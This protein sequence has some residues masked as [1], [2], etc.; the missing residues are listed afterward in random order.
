VVK[1]LQLTNKEIDNIIDLALA[2]DVSHGDV[3]SETLIPLGLQGQASILARAEGVLAGIEVVR[4]VFLRVD[5]LLKFERRLEDGARVRLG[6]GVANISGRVVSILKGERVVLNFLSRLSGVATAT[7]RFVAEVAGL[8][9]K[10]SDTRKTTPGLRQ[11]EK[12]A[13]RVGGGQNHRLHLGDGVLIKDNHI[14]ALRALGMSLKDIV[15]KAK[16][17]APQG[18]TVEVEVSRASE[19]R[20]AAEGGADIIMLDNISPGE[21]HRIRSLLPSYIKIE[22]SGG[23]TLESVHAAA[24]AGVDIISVGALTHSVKALD[25]SLE[26]EPK[27]IKNY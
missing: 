16:Q 7:A 24:Q 27:T 18:L 3:T 20:E 11:L 17:G 19:A 1:N 22:A 23:I 5:P 4:R 15:V 9:V 10:I 21:M 26:F 8:R 14:T 13:V 6:D 2:E 12:Y 25:F